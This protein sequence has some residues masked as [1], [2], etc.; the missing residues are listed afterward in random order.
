M[1]KRISY[2][3]STC[4]NSDTHLKIKAITYECIQFTEE[5]IAERYICELVC[6]AVIMSFNGR[7]LS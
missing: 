3:V 1:K 6:S 2:F 4:E 5:D 7:L